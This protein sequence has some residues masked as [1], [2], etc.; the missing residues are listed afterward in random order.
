[1][2][3][4]IRCVVISDEKDI[5]AFRFHLKSHLHFTDHWILVESENNIR[6][7]QPFLRPVGKCNVLELLAPAY[8]PRFTFLREPIDNVQ[9]PLIERAYGLLELFEKPI[10]NLPDSFEYIVVVSS[11]TEMMESR[12]IL[13]IMSKI[14][15]VPICVYH[16]VV[17][18]DCKTEEFREG[19][20]IFNA[21]VLKAHP[22]TWI[23]NTTMCQTI[24]DG[25]MYLGRATQ[26]LCEEK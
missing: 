8:W 22:M 13:R 24:Q 26:Y 1:M 10:L 6:T 4:V 15:H 12:T 20:R 2:L 23:Y 18:N 9:L 17:N 14:T 11:V 21:K 19:A 7:N 3:K 5:E 16:N 25:Y